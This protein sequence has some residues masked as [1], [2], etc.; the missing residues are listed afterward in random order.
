MTSYREIVTSLSF[1]QF[2]ANLQ[3]SGC[4]IP[5]AQPVKLTF[6][7]IVVT[8]YL[9]KTENTMKKSHTSHTI[10]V[11]KGLFMP[12]KMLIFLQKMLTSVKL[13][14]PWYEQV[15]FLKLHLCVYLCTKFQVYR[16]V[17]TS[18][19]RLGLKKKYRHAGV[20]L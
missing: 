6:S 20:S 8:F 10:A 17:S 7:L 2:M 15:C 16:I 11:S 9:I 13:R 14:R 12:K 1:L 3:R 18:P 19:C 5:N 4:Q